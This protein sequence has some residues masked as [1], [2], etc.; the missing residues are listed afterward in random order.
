MR[1]RS[2][3]FCSLLVLAAGPAAAMDRSPRAR[4]W[5]RASDAARSVAAIQRARE[6]AGEAR[7][8]RVPSATAFSG[9]PRP[10]ALGT[11]AWTAGGVPVCPAGLGQFDPTAVSDAAGGVVAAWIDSRNSGFDVYAARLD[12]NGNPLW[13]AAGVV[14][15]ASDSFMI[16]PVSVPDG[17]GGAFVVW[18]LFSGSAF[19]DVRVQHVTALGTIPVGWPPNGRSTVPGG[20]DGFG[21][22]PTNDGFLLMGWV[23]LAGQIRVVRLTGAGGLAPGWVAAG[24]A[25]GSSGNFNAEV[26]ATTD[27]AG[28]GYLC[29]D[30]AGTAVVTRIG[31]GGTFPSGW[32]AAGT[33]LGV[34]ALSSGLGVAPIPGGDAMVFWTDF[35][36]FN[37]DIFAQRYTAAG[38]T[39]AG[40]PA[41]G[42]P[43]LT[44]AALEQLPDPVPDGAGGAAV[45]CEIGAADSMVVQRMTGAGARAAGWPAAGVTLARNQGKT[46]SN[47]LAD[48]LG[49]A[50]LAW[51]ATKDINNQSDIFAS[52]AAP[53][54][55]VAV[56][57][58]D[59]VCGVEGSQYD[60]VIVTDGA[61]G[62]IAVWEDGRDMGSLQQIF[63]A[64]VTFDGVV[65]TLASLVSAS[66]EPGIARLHWYT[67]DGAAFE[68]GLERA[69]GEEAFVEIAR[70]TAEAGHVR[71]DDRDVIGG[72][73]YRYQLAVREGGTVRYLGAV[74]LRVPEGLSLSLLGLVPNP[75]A[76][77]PRL[78]YA[79]PTA[80]PA[81]IEVLDLAGRRVHERALDST[82]GEHVV[83]F[84]GPALAPGVYVLRLTQGTRSATA[85]AVVVR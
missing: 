81:R 61:A 28:G 59:T 26:A 4:G 34:N 24:H 18:G 42:V 57:W 69:R 60:P 55:T 49:G 15:C 79:L 5:V 38:A 41:D 40:W 17:S 78:V 12:G 37:F 51:S 29:W 33:P 58:P 67:G 13:P 47:A 85:R 76:G 45:I 14:L 30:D 16:Q 63:A 39:G 73:T 2:V 7:A 46:P 31:S 6:A 62:M 70:L 75:V 43:V 65:G 44:G 35:R 56:G 77:A 84:D 21:V 82:A 22:I 27:G 72:E 48:G 10:G 20:A 52:R 25:V 23:D 54:G 83:A 32:S 19:A 80:A 50:L 71:Y 9:D 74:T 8:T 53:G 68:A 1:L 3:L 66:A 36:N 64:R 11:I